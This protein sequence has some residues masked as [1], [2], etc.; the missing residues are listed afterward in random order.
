[1]LS[2]DRSEHYR[3]S[4]VL[5]AY[6]PAWI[7]RERPPVHDFDDVRPGRS[8]ADSLL[9]RP[10]TDLVSATTYNPMGELLTMTGAGGAPSESRTYNSIGQMT[11]LTNGSLVWG[12]GQ[13]A[14]LSCCTNILTFPLKSAHSKSDNR[15]TAREAEEREIF[16]KESPTNRN[17]GAYY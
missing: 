14:D 11:A 16:P 4:V 12:S 5:S 2:F 10:T 3:K 1:M 7:D 6:G 17:R 9:H 8:F 15:T 13:S